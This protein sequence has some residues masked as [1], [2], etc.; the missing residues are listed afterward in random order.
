MVTAN[1]KRLVRRSL[2]SYQKQTYPNKE[3]VI[4]DD[5]KEDLS[6]VLQSL[7]K[8]EVKYN[9]IP[10]RPDNVLGHLRNL[11][12]EMASGDILVQWDDDD[13]YHPER[14]QVQAEVLS[15]EAEMC[16]LSGALFH[17]DTKMFFNHPFVSRFRKGVPGSIMHR[18]NPFIRY[19]GIPLGEDDIYLKAW[20]KRANVMLGAAHSF[21]FIR[22]YHGKN[23]WEKGHFMKRLYD[24][25]GNSISYAWNRFIGKDLLK[26][27]LF[28]L[29]EKC[30]HS[31]RM[32][33]EDSISTGVF[34]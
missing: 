33:I 3:I 8:D 26:H 4:V 20:K 21:L 31:F 2:L 15:G 17:L 10:K 29:D 9:K 30:R 16:C 13:W 6:D 27:R 34:S 11:T 19:P 7:T 32:Y 23:S 24:S 28:K 12:L 5:G 14:L 18:K 25:P 22:S 1:R